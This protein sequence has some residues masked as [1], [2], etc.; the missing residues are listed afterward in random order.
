MKISAYLVITVALLAPSVAPAQTAPAM[1]PAGA[2]GAS[3][4]RKT[5]SDVIICKTYTPLGSRLGGKKICGTKEQF[6]AGARRSKEWMDDITV[7]TTQLCNK[8]YNPGD[9]SHTC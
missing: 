6:E 8:P 4:P 7:R 9:P 5:K 2:P 3:G 1:D